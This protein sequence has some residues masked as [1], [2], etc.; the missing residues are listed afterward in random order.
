M[1][2]RDLPVYRAGTATRVVALAA[3]PAAARAPNE[4]R[5]RWPRRLVSQRSGS[6]AT[7]GKWLWGP[8]GVYVSLMSPRGMS[9]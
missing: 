7:Y 5:R 6:R 4:Q 9:R 2:A 3:A 8:S 1:N